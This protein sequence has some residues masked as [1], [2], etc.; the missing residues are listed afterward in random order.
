MSITENSWPDDNHS[1]LP[2]SLDGVGDED[3]DEIQANFEFAGYDDADSTM[4]ERFFEAEDEK[5]E[6]ED[7]V[8]GNTQ[9]PRETSE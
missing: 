2:F 8:V 5:E 4:I 7:S 1:S 9:E 6:E 3:P